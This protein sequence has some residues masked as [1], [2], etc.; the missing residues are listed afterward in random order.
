MVP[1]AVR[2][3][4][5]DP[6]AVLSELARVAER[7]FDTGAGPRWRNASGLAW[8]SVP[9]RIARHRHVHYFDRV[10]RA[11]HSFTYVTEGA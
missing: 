7:S 4:D 11:F 1:D 6:I 8:R 5:L 9:N 10:E 2:A 3:S